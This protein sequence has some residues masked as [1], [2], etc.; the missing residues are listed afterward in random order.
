MLTQLIEKIF[1][2]F[3]RYRRK[4]IVKTHQSI[5]LEDDDLKLL[6]T[7]SYI[8]NA[9][10]GKTINNII[11]VVV[12]TTKAS[13]PDDFDINKQSLKYDRDNKVIK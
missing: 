7:V 10:I 8:K 12:E 9:T 1:Q 11:K 2:T 3:I 5:Y 13:L 6:K 4:K